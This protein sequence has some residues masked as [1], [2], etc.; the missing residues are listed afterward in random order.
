[1]SNS[2]HASWIQAA[3]TLLAIGVAIYIPNSH[4]RRDY[5]ERTELN[6]KIVMS[7]AANLA[8][9]LQYETVITDFLPR[10]DGVIGHDFT[11]DQAYAVMKLRAETLQALNMSLDKSHYFDIRLCEKIVNLSL[12]AA[13][14]ERIL[15]DIRLRPSS[16]NPDRFLQLTYT[17]REKLS[18]KFCEVIRMLEEYLPNPA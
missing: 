11:T 18:S 12:E 3:G 15:E 1:M 6:K 4:K 8:T 14:Y 7:A 9:A 13:A 10:G 17:S 16:S 5:L 2:E